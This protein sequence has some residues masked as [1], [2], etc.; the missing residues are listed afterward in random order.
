MSYNVELFHER[1]AATSQ[2]ANAP[3][4]RAPAV[5]SEK[6]LSAAALVMLAP[7]LHPDIICIE[8]CCEQDELDRFNKQWLK[9]AYETVIVFPTNS[10]R[11][12][13]LGM[14]LKSAASRCW[15]GR[16]S[17]TWKRTR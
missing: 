17:I 12:Q 1:F 11:H 14:M 16:I 8:E 10:D 4:G 6:K 7:A 13:Q 3:A 5:N 2:P 15:S 9:G